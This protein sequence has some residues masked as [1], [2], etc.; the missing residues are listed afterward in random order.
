MFRWACIAFSVLLMGEADVPV[1]LHL[2]PPSQKQVEFP[3]DQNLPL[4]PDLGQNSAP[5]A[6]KTDAKT[7]PKSASKTAPLQPESRL[8][9][10][11]FVSGEFAKAI[12]PLPSGKKGFRM[13]AG[14]PVDDKA[15]RVAVSRSGPAV[16]T[17]DQ[18]QITRIEFKDHE[19]V[20]DL[21][22]GGRQKTRWRDRVQVSLGG[23]GPTP[24]VS[25]GG[26][27]SAAPGYQG[28]GSTLYLE[29]G[30][31]LP[32]MTPDELKQMLAGILDFSKQRSAAVQWVQTLPP[33]VQQAI[34]DKKVIAGMSQEEVVAAVGKPE[35]KVRERDATGNEVEDWIYGR[36]PDKMTFVTFLGDKVV[37]VRE[38]NN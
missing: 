37:R 30:K 12:R 18:V 2:K 20:F 15:L 28:N 1:V 14:K 34:K 32:D 33:E 3:P 23:S 7:D 29:F 13:A 19:I 11:R 8:A 38:Y 9:I 35:R 21:N 17:G 27:G 25:A 36:P 24:G 16:N 22:G 6:Q 5:P 31:S 4:L 26:V 10:V